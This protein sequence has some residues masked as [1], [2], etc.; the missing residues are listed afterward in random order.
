MKYI[1]MC[2]GI[3]AASCAWHTETKWGKPLE[4]W[5]P[6]CFSEIEPFPSA[7]LKHRFPN[8]PNVGDMTKHDWSQYR[9][10]C[11]LLI[12]GTPCQA[13]SLAGLREGLGDARGN[14][15]LKFVE[16]I[17][18]IRP[19][20]VVW[21]NVCGALSI[22]DNAFGCFLGGL[23]GADQPLTSP[24]E[25]GRWAN[26][27]IVVGPIYGICW[28][29]VDA[30]HWGVPQ[31][32]RRIYAAG[33]LG[34]WRPA[35]QV[36]FE[37]AGMPRYHSESEEQGQ[38]AATDIAACLRSGG[39][40][41]VPS[42]RGEHIVPAIAGCLQERDSKGADSDTKPG[43]LIPAIAPT[44]CSKWSKGTGGP[45]G[46]ECGNLIAVPKPCLL[47]MREGCDGGGKGPLISEDKSLTLATGNN[48]VLF[49]PQIFDPYNNKADDKSTALGTNCGMST[50]RSILYG[51][52]QPPA[53]EV[54]SNGTGG[55]VEKSPT[56]DT[57]AEDGPRRNQGGLI[58]PH[59]P[60]VYENHGQDSRIKEVK[61]APQL[62]AKAGTGGNN[63]PLVAGF[64]PGQSAGAHSIGYEEGKSPTLE[65]GGGGNNN[66]AIQQGMAVRRL[67][68]TEC[69]RLQGF[70]DGWTKVPFK[71][72]SAEAC[73]DGNRYKA[74]GNSM[75]V[76]VVRWIGER[77]HEVSNAKA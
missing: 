62:N 70:P 57:R 34:D 43:H 56:L 48:Q 14:L 12:A 16:A 2:S 50:G 17:H 72:K 71:N 25:Q 37:P 63:L 52:T 3:E 1:S 39:R 6:I 33:Y 41:G 53:W 59:P 30:Q 68:P 18:A 23:A 13:F 55:P 32:R 26:A 77:I 64:K 76:P 35:A 67:T 36:L 29:V 19:T 28:R 22:E 46:S 51:E 4:G 10:Q 61:V 74:C 66:P 11:D 75:A 31:R 60:T 40:G 54:T 9:G 27:G 47:T 15:T 73:P 45:A 58:I 38:G 21:E 69:E 42:S 65:G 20:W 8:T 44:V 24:L 5:E 49:A 7:V